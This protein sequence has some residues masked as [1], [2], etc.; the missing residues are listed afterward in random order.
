VIRKSEDAGNRGAGD[1]RVLLKLGCH[2]EPE[3]EDRET[4]AIVLFSTLL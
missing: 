4:H 2:G 1:G 3:P